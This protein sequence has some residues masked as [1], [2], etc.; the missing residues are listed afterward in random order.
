MKNNITNDK[1]K[2]VSFSFVEADTAVHED[3][4]EDLRQYEGTADEESP[5]DQEDTIILDSQAGI[6]HDEMV[7]LLN[8]SSRMA[9]GIMECMTEVSHKYNISYFAML[10][11][12]ALG[13][14]ITK[15]E[16]IAKLSEMGGSKL[17]PDE[18][19]TIWEEAMQCAHACYD[20]VIKPT[21]KK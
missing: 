8:A 10:C 15:S 16:V 6:D 19:H 12:L 3:P 17:T 18:E 5:E 11:I 2:K 4:V 1:R 9:G 21:I 20:M 14:D 7:R 13:M